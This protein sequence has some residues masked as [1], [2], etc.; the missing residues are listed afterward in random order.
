MDCILSVSRQARQPFGMFR[1]ALSFRCDSPSS[2]MRWALWTRRSRMASPK[3]GSGI[4]R[5]QSETGTWLAIRMAV[6]PKRSSNTSH[7]KSLAQSSQPFPPGYSLLPRKNKL[8][9][10]PAPKWQGKLFGREQQPLVRHGS[11]TQEVSLTLL[12]FGCQT[13]KSQWVFDAEATS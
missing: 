9:D 12:G 1:C 8:Q 5:C 10:R 7:P 3:V 13:Q 11:K 4:R 6:W 2:W